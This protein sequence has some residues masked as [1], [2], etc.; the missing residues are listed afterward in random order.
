MRRLIFESAPSNDV[1]KGLKVARSRRLDAA[2][3]C[4]LNL[5]EDAFVRRQSIVCVGLDSLE[6]LRLQFT[7]ITEPMR[8]TAE[9]CQGKYF[10]RRPLEFFFARRIFIFESNR[11]AAISALHLPPILQGKRCSFL[12]LLCFCFC[13]FSC[14][15]TADAD[16]WPALSA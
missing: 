8:F 4:L 13:P 6:D 7:R 3:S 12:L 15:V 16:V 5:M 14:V 10:F 11:K 9:L 2:F 1:E